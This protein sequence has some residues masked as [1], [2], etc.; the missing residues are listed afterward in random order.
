MLAAGVIAFLYVLF[1][2]AS[3]PDEH[4]GLM[5]F[6]QGEMRALR[7]MEE[8]PP[9][10]TRSLQG[11]EGDTSLAAFEGEILVVNLW[12]TWCAPCVEEMPT[13]AALQQS[14]EG[15]IRVIPISVDSEAD[16]ERA[17]RKLEDLSGGG[18]PFY[19]DIT[20][21]VLF[22]L[23]ATGMPVTV[24]YDRNGVE[25]ARLSGGADWSSLEARALMEGV[26]AGE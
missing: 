20:R 21:G 5:R 12:A 17:R 4:V 24:I 2:A 22:D 13:L 1:F 3:K 7:I 23:H 26:L 25:M 19:S 15:R 11:P 14:F 16:L 8:A 9:M 10:P 6:A 18:L